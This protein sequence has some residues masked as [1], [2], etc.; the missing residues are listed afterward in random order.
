MTKLILA[1]PLIASLNITEL[2]DPGTANLLLRYRGTEMSGG[3]IDQGSLHVNT[4]TTGSPGY[5]GDGV[6]CSVA[7]YGSWN[8]FPAGSGS[9]FVPLEVGD[10]TWCGW[11][12]PVTRTDATAVPYTASLHFP[13]NAW[14]LGAVAIGG[15]SPNDG[16]I[17]MRGIGANVW[18]DNGGGSEIEWGSGL[19]VVNGVASAGVWIHIAAVYDAT[20]GE[21]RLYLNGALEDT[22][23]HVPGIA[24]HNNVR[25]GATSQA[26]TMVQTVQSVANARIADCRAYNRVLTAKEIEFVFAA[27]RNP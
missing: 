27:G 13:P 8:F 23:A 22:S 18:S 5:S 2:P 3:L 7:G 16:N 25:L 26:G 4:S 15:G 19:P 1:D 6:D 12:R 21:S 20:H 10:G 24:G 14:F 9:V 17:T 11:V